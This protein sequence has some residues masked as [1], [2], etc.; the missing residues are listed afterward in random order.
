MSKIAVVGAGKTG[1]GFVGRLLKE[2][3]CE[4]LFVDKDADLVRELNEKGSFRITF[5][6]DSRPEL[7][8]D[9][10]H[11]CTWE[12]ADFSDVELIFVSVCGS[13]LEAAGKSLKEKLGPAPCYIITCENASHPSGILRREIGKE[14]VSISEA[15][16]FCTTTS[17]GGLDIHSENYPYLQC[18]AQLLNGYVPPVKGVKPIEQFGNFL[19]RKLF[20]YN[21]ASCVI[22]YLGYIRGYT[23]YG[24]A[25][26]DPEILALLDRNYTVTNRVLCREFGYDEKDQQE[27]AALSRIKFCDRTI[28]DTVARNAREPQ[29]KLTNQE[30]VIGPMLLLQKYGEDTA[31]LEMTAGAM[32]VYD[33]EGEKEWRRIKEKNSYEEILEKICG[34]ERGNP[35][36]E[37]ILKYAREYEKT[38]PKT[39]TKA[40]QLPPISK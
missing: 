37:R 22:A 24:E 6:G 13:N 1:R 17:D 16:V 36:F 29:R 12:E 9:H 14:N 30:R 23:D 18:D 25:A 39:E 27:F 8:V 33:N 38:F 4:I 15:T 2:D 34:L 11:A 28:S 35:L 10:Y 20:T 40:S 21:A 31:V 26:N 7:V 5:F 32:L 3:D 19:M